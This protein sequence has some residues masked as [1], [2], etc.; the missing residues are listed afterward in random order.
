MPTSFFHVSA[1]DHPIGTTL[2]PG[3]FGELVRA[4]RVRQTNVD[5]QGMG[6]LAWESSLEVARCCLAPQAPSRLACVFATP[7]LQEAQQF[8][9]RLRA[10]AHIFQIEA[11]DATLV[12]LADFE[13]ITT[14]PTG[15]PFL[16]CYV[17][18]AMAYWVQASVSTLRE[19][20]I[21]GPVNVVRKLP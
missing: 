16:D 6:T 2:Q 10:G 4:P 7:T 20:L 1:T 9:Q 13:S 18:A 5:A 15:K 17:D 21:G 14:L 19:A 8:R 11:V 12:H 3:R